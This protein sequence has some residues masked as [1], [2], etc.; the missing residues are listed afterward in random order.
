[1]SRISG[2]VGIATV[3][4]LTTVGFAQEIVRCESNDMRRNFCDVSPNREI[5]FARQVS[6]AKCIPGETFGTRGTTIWVDRGCRGDF[7]VYRTGYGRPPGQPGWQ[8]GAWQGG[9]AP[10][11]IKCESNNG[12]YKFCPGPGF[13]VGRAR[14]ARQISGSA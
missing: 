7:Q 14:L 13:P 6:D 3:V 5:R 9:S 1:V 4:L 11:T 2:L 10:M 8:G 12:G